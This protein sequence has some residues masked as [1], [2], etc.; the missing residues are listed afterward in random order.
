MARRA[1][2]GTSSVPNG[3]PWNSLPDLIDGFEGL[4]GHASKGSRAPVGR[5]ERSGENAPA[6]D[7]RPSDAFW[8]RFLMS[9][10]GRPQCV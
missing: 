1:E 5:G 4:S 9:C 2:S 6:R 10:A 8:C 7:G 3:A